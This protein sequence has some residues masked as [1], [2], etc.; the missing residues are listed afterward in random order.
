MSGAEHNGGATRHRHD[1]G[2]LRV[3]R[4]LPVTGA[5][6]ELGRRV[7][8]VIAARVRGRTRKLFA[9]LVH[10]T[11]EQFVAPVAGT[12]GS[13]R[14]TLVHAL[15]AEWGLLDRC[16][17]PESHCALSAVLGPCCA[18][19]GTCSGEE[20]E[21]IAS[22]CKSLRRYKSSHKLASKDDDTPKVYKREEVLGVPRSE[23]H[24]F[25]LQSRQ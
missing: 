2:R 20:E 10:L 13:I 7:A 11:A 3:V 16:G 6:A 24:T 9:A 19:E 17:G 18:R 8:A 15:S 23:E 12:Y 1:R 14:N 22:R 5:H 21:A 4:V 25:E